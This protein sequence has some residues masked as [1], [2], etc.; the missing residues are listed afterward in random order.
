LKKGMDS[1][2]AA[3]VRKRS[4]SVSDGVLDVRM[5]DLDGDFAVAGR[6]GRREGGEKG[7]G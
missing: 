2:P 5:D 4:R 3:M 1:K 7:G 6:R